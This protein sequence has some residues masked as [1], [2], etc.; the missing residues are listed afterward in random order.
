MDLEKSSPGA[1][2]KK[3]VSVL[4]TILANFKKVTF[5]T[6]IETYLTPINTGYVTHRG[7]QGCTFNEINT[8]PTLVS[9][10]LIFVQ[11]SWWEQWTGGPN[12]TGAGFSL[13]LLSNFST[14]PMELYNPK[15]CDGITYCS[16]GCLY[17]NFG[18]RG[19]SRYSDS[20]KFDE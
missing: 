19:S 17:H 14:A 2:H 4:R 15:H 13:F 20:P 8:F 11:Y 3:Y 16:L 18:H 10:G 6:Q 5:I 1:N 12:F 9:F 7:Q